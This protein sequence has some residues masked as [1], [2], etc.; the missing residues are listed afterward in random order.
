MKGADPK[1]FVV[2]SEF[3]GKDNKFAFNAEKRINGADGKSF[4]LIGRGPYAK[5]KKDFYYDT[6]AL[7]T[8]IKT[9]KI[10]D[11]NWARDKNHYYI[12]GWTCPI[13]DYKTFIALDF[14]YAKDKYKVYCTDTTVTNADPATFKVNNDGSGEDKYAKYDGY[15]RTPK[16]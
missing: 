4:E 7:K 5:D 13:A 1:T 10:F 12:N 14:M 8:D 11:K 16:P 3:Y 6:V 15:Q 2:V 9:F